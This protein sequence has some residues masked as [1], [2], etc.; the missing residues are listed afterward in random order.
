MREAEEEI[1][2]WAEWRDKVLGR[3]RKLVDALTDSELDL[4]RRRYHPNRL[5]QQMREVGVTPRW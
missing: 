1:I 3:L 4:I 2:Q 5:A